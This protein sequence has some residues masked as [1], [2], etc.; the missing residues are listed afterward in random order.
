M[1]APPAEGQLRTALR[2]AWVVDGTGS[3]RRRAT[4][5]LQAGRIV[6][7]GGDG[8]A[9]DGDRV[10]DLDGLVLAPGFIDP[11]THYDAQVLWD[12]D[13]TPSSWHGVTTVVMGN[14]GFG[15]A[16]TRPEHRRVVLETLENVEGMSLAALEAGLPWRFE[17]FPEYLAQV[18]ARPR[19][20]NVG[21][22]IGHTPVRT[23]VMG[24]DA[25][26]RHAT[27]AEVAAM[28]RLVSE[29]MDAGALGFSSSRSQ[30]HRGAGGKP[31]PSRAGSLDEVFALAGALAEQGRGVIQAT[32]GPD[33]FVDEFARLAAVTGRPVT[34]AAL[35]TLRGD[36]GYARAVVEQVNQRGGDVYPQ[37]ACRPI[38]ARVTLADPAP[39][40]NVPAFGEALMAPRSERGHIYADP[41]WQDRAATEMEERWPGKLAGATVEETERHP[42]LRSG[43]TLADIG[44][45]LGLTPLQA[46]VR[47]ALEERLETR[48]R[49]VMTNDDDDQIGWLLQ[50]DRFLLGLS[51]AGAHATQLCD[52]NYATYLLGYWVRERGAL[53]LEKAVWRLTGH[54]AA[55]FGIADR[56]RIAPGAAADLV[57]FD[58]E[59]VEAAPLERVWDF[60]GDSDRLVSRSRGIHRV[61]VNGTTVVRDG[62]LVA[63]AR[64]GCI[65][66]SC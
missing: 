19:R 21:F 25:T 14:C 8:R 11:H 1:T 31:V 40:A 13:L 23:W 38:V 6:E 56:G 35:M 45:R 60:P 2:G 53:S 22:L 62:E 37:I 63:G 44:A 29:G 32:W 49:V 65:I 43:P 24:A 47:L 57:A 9:G 64:P 54:P 15:I 26:E 55:V 41:A 48:F 59:R 16:P 4:V 18:A 5:V 33:L 36:P 61:W 30:S 42:E 58:P 27:A 52:A 10:V 20:L 39:L 17:T 34:W 66:R 3:A 7:V 12:P 28:R 50:Q 51:D 46:M